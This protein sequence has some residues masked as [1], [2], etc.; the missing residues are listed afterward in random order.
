MQ[1]IFTEKAPKAIGPYS[2]AV[3]AGNLLFLSGQIPVDPKTNEVVENDIEVQTN[4]VMKNI[5]AILES[6][7]LSV[8]NIVK[9]TIFLKDMNQFAVVNE[10]YGKH[11]GDHRPARS[12]VE[13]S[14]LP[15]DV[16]IEIEVIAFK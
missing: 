11:L 15:K 1:T 13:I 8:N 10:E 5:K 6:Q 3:E 16:L 4:Q 14:R 7:Q 2:Q 9:T 12:T